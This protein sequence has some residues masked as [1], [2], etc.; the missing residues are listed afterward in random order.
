MTIPHE[1]TNR[2]KR[3]LRSQIKT[4]FRDKKVCL[5]LS[6]GADSTLLGLVAHS[7]KLDVHAVSYERQGFPSEDCKQAEIT[8]THYGW[9]FTKVII[10]K[11]NPKDCFMKMINLGCQTKIQLEVM[12]PFVHLV[13]ELEAQGFDLVMTGL[14]CPIPDNRQASVRCRNNPQE[15]WDYAC[16]TNILST[17]SMKCIEFA[18]AR[19]IEIFNPLHETKV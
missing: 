1:T 9:D 16:T 7:L 18:A 2:L 3:N 15:W 17:A 12:Y 10:P 6:A 13:D 4:K 8:A 11:E 5:L 14:G 19:N